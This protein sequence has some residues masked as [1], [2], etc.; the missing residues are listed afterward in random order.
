M[1]MYAVVYVDDDIDLPH[2]PQGVELDRAWQSKRGLDVYDGPYRITR[3]GRLEKKRQSY[4]DK[5]D[6]EKRAEAE[7]WGYGSWDEYVQAY[8]EAGRG[9]PQRPDYID[10]DA[11]E[12]GY[13]DAP[14]SINPRESTLDE[15]WWDDQCFHGT[16]EFHSSVR[17][18]PVSYEMFERLGG[19][20]VKRPDEYALDVFI[21]YEARFREGDLEEVMF[22]G[23]RGL[24]D[25]DPIEH[26]L[27]QIKEWR[28]W[29]QEGYDV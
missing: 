4:R 28:K 15:E 14:P 18:D 21:E 9:I 10:W 26:A 7:K 19:E 8:E 2:F 22:M 12:D 24:A 3:D 1:G 11:E 5:T 20:M 27:E 23:S 13:E 16:F 29:R 25:D 6:E 17:E